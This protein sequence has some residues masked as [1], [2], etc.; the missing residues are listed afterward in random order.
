MKLGRLALA[1]IAATVGFGS[2]ALAANGS[3]FLHLYNGTDFFFGGFVNPQFPV[4][5]NGVFRCFPSDQLFAPTKVVGTTTVPAGQYATKIC[6]LHFG[7]LTS[8][9]KTASW[10]T[11]ALSSSD[12]DCRFVIG[13]G[14]NFGLASATAFGAPAGS[15]YFIFGPLNASAQVNLLALISG[16][17][18]VNPFPLGTAVALQLDLNAVFGAP[19]TIAVP[20]GE[21]L[22]YWQA[23]D[24]LDAPGAYQYWI[25]SND[26]RNICSSMSYFASALTG[27]GGAVFAFLP[28]F[29]WGIFF[30]TLDATMS[31]AVAPSAA[32]VG[33]AE[34]HQDPAAYI[35]RMDVGTGGR[36]FS[37]TGLTPEGGNGLGFE[38]LSLLTYD[39]NNAFG[40][41]GRLVFANLMSVNTGAVGSCGPWTPGY[42]AV[43]TGGPGG[44]ALSNA[45]PQ[46]PRIVGQLDAVAL[47]LIGNPVWV[48]STSHNTLAGGGGPPPT[49]AAFPLFANFPVAHGGSTGNSGGF[50]IPV[51]AIP[52]L[53]GLEVFL[54]SVGLNGAGTSI[55][56]LANNGHSHSN[57]FPIKFHP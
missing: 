37:L 46:M 24:P 22:T 3:N 42:F 7:T 38:T 20:E 40:G 41:S 10:P 43:P 54:S 12:G 2:D 27:A 34:T 23:D 30:G 13:S 32:P 57:G 51:P 45:I 47:A 52:T 48:L 9:G 28:T 16:L 11:I 44:P 33:G 36:T 18:F 35:N 49:A 5:T 50:A 6:A 29:E 1:A 4:G 56:K 31:V 53:I 14:L 39:E 21:A 19:S 26:E 55:A 17:Q 15:G 25:G 8:T